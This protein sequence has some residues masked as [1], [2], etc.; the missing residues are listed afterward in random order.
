MT[1]PACETDS[2]PAGRDVARYWLSSKARTPPLDRL[3]PTARGRAGAAGT[4]R[5]R[6]RDARD[7]VARAR[8]AALVP[9]PAPTTR[10][11]QR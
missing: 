10:S 4:C 1:D 5:A 11:I 2:R 8:R 3:A 7:R 6:N 9:E